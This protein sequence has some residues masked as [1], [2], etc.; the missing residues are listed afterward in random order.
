M[1]KILILILFYICLAYG[2]KLNVPRVLL[3]LFKDV[4]SNF[5]LEVKD[6]GCY[7]WSIS[8]KDVI[9]LNLI[10]PDR[11]EECSSQAQI[12]TI[13][14]EFTRNTV[15]VLL[16]DVVSGQILR[17]DVIVDVIY[18]LNITTTTRELFIEE[19]PEK[20]EVRAF[21]EQGN[22]F[23]TLDGIQF[24][25]TIS[26][27]S[28]HSDYRT[29]NSV[30]RF[31][32]FRD[33][34]YEVP[35]AIKSLD[36]AG[37]QGHTVL[38]EG[39]KTGSAK[40]SVELPQAEYEK[41]AP[42]DV[43]LVVVANLLLEPAD[44]YMMKGDTL[45]FKLLQVQHGKLI[46]IPL[47]SSQY[48]FD[49]EDLEIAKVLNNNGLVSA[50]KLGRTKLTLFDRNV[51]ERDSVRLPQAHITV[52]DPARIALNLLPYK[53]W[54]VLMNEPTS[55]V[56]EIFTAEG[57][58]FSIGDGVRV[59]S[60]IPRDFYQV[61]D[62][63]YNGTYHFGT[64]V[65]P[66]VAQIQA[67]LESITTPDD[68]TI[69]FKKPLTAQAEMFIY[70]KIQVVPSETVLAWDPIIKPKYD[71][72][73]EATGGDGN[74][75]WSVANTT[76]AAA[77]SS[78][79]IKVLS[80]GSTSVFASMKK[81][82]HNYG[83]GEIHV[84]LPSRLEIV[85][86]VL[87]EEINRPIFIHVALFGDRV[88]NN[89]L[90]RVRITNCHLI[91]F[92]ITSSDS[93]F[94]LHPQQET[95]PAKGACATVAVVSSTVGTAKITV[96]YSVDGDSFEDTVTVG[97]YAPLE[98]V[99]PVKE[100]VLALASSRHIVFRKGP[101]P[102]SENGGSYK[103]Q[104]AV[105]SDSVQ[106]SEVTTFGKSEPNELYVYTVECLKIGESIVSLSISNNP[107]YVRCKATEAIA[108]VKVICAKP[109]YIVLKPDVSNF[110]EKCPMNPHSDWIVAHCYQNIEVA[111]TIKDADGRV[112]DNAT[113]LDTNWNVASTDL[114]SVAAP[115]MIPLK[116][117]AENNYL[118]PESHFQVIIPK[119]ITGSMKVT[120]SLRGYR[121][122]MLKAIGVSAE[123][124][125]F[126]VKNEDGYEVTPE[127]KSSIVFLLVDDTKILPNQ[128]SIL[129]HPEDKISLKV[130]EG[131]GFYSL[132]VSGE[133][134][135]DVKYDESSRSIEV[136][137]LQ[138]GAIRIVL[139]DLCLKGK[140]AKAQI[141][142]VRIGMIQ[143]DMIDKIE[144]GHSTV[145]KVKVLDV[146]DNP[147]TVLRPDILGLSAHV[148]QNIIS[149][150]KDFVD[151]P[152]KRRGK[153]G[154]SFVVS[155][156][157]LGSTNLIFSSGDG[158]RK[159]R[160]QQVSVHVF[161]PL[162]LLPRD[163]TITPGARFQLSSMGG[164][165]PDC[166][167]EFVSNN[168][169]VGKVNDAGLVEGLKVGDITVQG[170]AV[171]FNKISGNRIVYSKSYAAVHIVPLEG[172]KIHSPIVRMKVGAKV[173]VWVGG[174]PD[175]ISPLI[176]GSI[177]PSLSFKWYVVSPDFVEIKDVL[178]E[179]GI[180]VRNEDRLSVRIRAL[181]AG[182]VSLYVNVTLPPGIH[183]QGLTH[184][185][186]HIELEIFEELKLTFPVQPSGCMSSN[187]LFAPNTVT[188]IRTNKD[189]DYPVSYSVLGDPSTS[190]IPHSSTVSASS[191][192]SVNKDGS[193]TTGNVF[194]RSIVVAHSTESSGLEQSVAFNIEVKPVHYLMLNVRSKLVVGED[195]TIYQLP[196]GINLE[197]FVSYHDKDGT[198]FTSVSSILKNQVNRFDLT[199]FGRGSSNNSLKVDLI[200][201]G[202]TVLKVWDEATPYKSGDFVKLS[203][204]YILFPTKSTVTVGE[205]ICFSMPMLQK[206]GQ[207]G[208][209]SSADPEILSVTNNGLGRV[210]NKHGTV[211]VSYQCPPSLVATTVIEVLPLHTLAFIPVLNRNISNARLEKPFTAPLLLLSEKDSYVK[212]SNLI[213]KDEDK[214]H[215]FNYTS[216]HYP[217]QCFVKLVDPN[218]PVD[219]RD[220]FNVYPHFDFQ[221][222]LY[223]CLF[224]PVKFPAT[225]IT[226]LLANL[227]VWAVSG[228]IE[229]D[230]II[231][232]FYSAITVETSS[233]TLTEKNFKDTFA[234]SGL[235]QVLSQVSIIGYEELYL[236]ITKR[237]INPEEKS[238]IVLDIQLNEV[239]WRAN[240]N[241][242]LDT[243]FSIDS[244]VTGQLIKIPIFIRLSNQQH[245]AAPCMIS[246][247]FTEPNYFWSDV[248][249]LFPIILS[250]I[251]CSLV[252]F[253]SF[254]KSKGY[255]I[256]L[257]AEPGGAP[258]KFTETKT[259][260]AQPR[261]SQSPGRRLYVHR[262]P[263]E[264]TPIYGSPK[265]TPSSRSTSTFSGSP[266]FV[267]EST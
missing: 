38:L 225:N 179:S 172:I 143:V 165:Q 112:F 32:S 184:L 245:Y 169:T 9:Q 166:I 155:G 124:P 244:P 236:T 65:K 104:I 83:I 229:S 96:S 228:N 57:H 71:I 238:V 190:P 239:Y 168:S 185:S 167:M 64:A 246:Y 222:G 257:F 66:G 256:G 138:S 12:S 30:L 45:R 194:G 76:V 50:E 252:S 110:G 62:E 108:Q 192:L 130:V 151:E 149:V 15:M 251:F 59:I 259:L 85:Q 24:K 69:P 53:N 120:A 132:T 103:R 34:P 224:E 80:L 19:A 188:K 84:L 68:D 89:I 174:I 42:A 28:W 189:G 11:K 164:P 78:G 212:S 101:K 20:F 219:I 128:T 72:K 215:T 46:E 60:S 114:G 98:V 95:T 233:M 136:T 70:S 121:S 203:V 74:F 182:K 47:A 141:N 102:W 213:A 51:D 214:C 99:H 39:R 231:Y 93:S 127:I 154:I 211:V 55:I 187:L 79:S 10:N 261:R 6:N 107:N 14:K 61:K 129:N 175:V 147:L 216:A 254:C 240:R 157:E 106:V 199:Q 249:S 137:P 163:L 158:E 94:V 242:D 119:N 183:A 250:I 75:E 1:T 176:L 92:N 133:S 198:E 152:Q 263:F 180:E 118:I 162:Q 156:N 160:S 265:L 241:K 223:S 116:Y 153:D 248:K 4:T 221:T 146:N 54:N 49:S 235:P 48:Y 97:A 31:I 171:G 29:D 56:V 258:P 22:Q 52:A 142:I 40:V 144:K 33:S 43:Q 113:S 8:R 109:R 21:D 202:E 77:K 135:A 26:S 44:A 204:D 16:E 134:F 193:V 264:S 197:F 200:E 161:P 234:I 88:V 232:S 73:L 148:D 125:V 260:P 262:T 17:C 226:H 209:W 100:T 126:G 178:H 67:K 58:K 18:A 90:K 13:S 205:I 82:I 210:K 253:Y 91:N 140:P 105:S 201:A 139:N 111:V 159:V 247:P 2:S 177:K 131:S 243:S 237:D 150:E 191:V 25:W 123:Y 206:S 5:T 186:D 36:D 218:I 41:V 266:F 207:F 63:A 227:S 217:F 35:L 37:L 196:R 173:P 255:S 230:P 181:K 87:E 267:N 117:R 27:N 122:Q 195:E 115:G 208:S 23:T 145:A 86:Y 7:K 220:I 170:Q 3:P 81:N